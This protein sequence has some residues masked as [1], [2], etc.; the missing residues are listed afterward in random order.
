MKRILILFFLYWTCLDCFSQK[1]SV[2]LPAQ[3]IVYA[4]VENPL[5]VVVE[6]TSCDSI[7]VRVNRGSISGKGCA[8]VYQV[9]EPS[10]VKI[11]VSRK[12]DGKWIKVGVE[13]LRAQSVPAPTPTIGITHSGTI[14]RKSLIACEGMETSSI[15]TC[16]LPRSRIDSFTVCIIRNDTCLYASIRNVGNR[17]N[18]SV[19]SAFR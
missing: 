1:L 2:A 7:K 4:G 15:L 11:F 14:S 5:T 3:N 16:S 10:L 8:Y 13:H 9:A 19:I 6:K 17:Y 12:K 18:D